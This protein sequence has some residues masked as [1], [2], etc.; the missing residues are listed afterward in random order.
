MVLDHIGKPDI[1]A[2]A[3][4]P[5]RQ[6]IRDL[7]ACPN[8]WCKLSGMVTEADPAAWDE[9]QLRPYFDHVIE[10]FGYDRLIF[11]SDWPVST[12][13]V[14]YGAWIE[15]VRRALDGAGPADLQKVFYDNAAAFYRIDA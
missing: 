1:R 3:L 9:D 11:G 5:W 4:D 15:T 10:C 7:A 12:L 14:E 8:V 2:G 6:G 13:G